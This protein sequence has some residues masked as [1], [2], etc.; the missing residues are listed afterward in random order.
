MRVL[1][2]GVQDKGSRFRRAGES[3]RFRHAGEGLG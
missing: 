3:P 1:V 2:L